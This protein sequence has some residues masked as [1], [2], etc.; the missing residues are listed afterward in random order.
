[1]QESVF[2]HDWVIMDASTGIV[3]NICRTVAHKNNFFGGE[4]Q[5]K[6][7]ESVVCTLK[8]KRTWFYGYRAD[9]Y[10]LPEVTARI[11]G[12]LLISASLLVMAA[13]NM[14]G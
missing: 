12:A 1:M 3:G 2:S 11:N 5:I 10:Y 8:L 4:C 6:I 13:W 9:L 14:S 7:D